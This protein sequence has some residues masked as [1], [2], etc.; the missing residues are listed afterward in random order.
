MTSFRP[1]H[2]PPHVT[3]AARTLD[4][5]KCS[6]PRGPA[7]WNARVSA[8]LFC[9]RTMST[10]TQS[11][12]LMIFEYTCPVLDLITE[13]PT[14]W[15][16]GATFEL[17]KPRSF[18]CW[19]AYSFTSV[20]ATSGI[21]TRF[22]SG[23][24]SSLSH[25]AALERATTMAALLAP[26]RSPIRNM[27]STKTDGFTCHNCPS[28]TGKF[29][30]ALRGSPVLALTSAGALSTVAVSPR[31]RAGGIVRARSAGRKVSK[32]PRFSPRA[33]GS[34]RPRRGPMPRSRARGRAQATWCGC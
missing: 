14:K 5:S 11:C 32:L 4:G 9:A 16:G 33:R 8:A 30:S 12:F 19:S 21:G 28:I 23:V 10:S 25:P 22:T 29:H 17:G 27:V 20:T 15:A 24:S 6:S 13:P 1:G 31:L 3:I 7:R 26:A 2:R 18:R 34:S